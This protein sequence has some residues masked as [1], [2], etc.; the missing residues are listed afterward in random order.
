MI[1]HKK[2]DLLIKQLLQKCIKHVER[3]DGW[4]WFWH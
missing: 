4:F 3:H 2:I 1:D